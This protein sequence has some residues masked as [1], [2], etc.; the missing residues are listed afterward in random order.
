M[1]SVFVCFIL[2]SKPQK[3]ANRLFLIPVK[4]KVALEITLSP[5]LSESKLA[6]TFCGFFFFCR[7]HNAD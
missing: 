3:A 4:L 2:L 1:L 6:D 5:V 7:C